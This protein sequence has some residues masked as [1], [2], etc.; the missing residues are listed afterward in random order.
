VSSSS[1]VTAKSLLVRRQNVNTKY[2]APGVNRLGH[3]LFEREPSDVIMARATCL[4]GQLAGNRALGSGVQTVSTGTIRT[5]VE[6]CIY[7]SMRS[8]VMIAN[9]RVYIR[10]NK[11]F[12]KVLYVNRFRT[13][14]R[15]AVYIYIYIIYIRHIHTICSFFVCF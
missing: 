9:K 13:H 5:S 15:N 8:I 11:T 7:S 12:G 4:V 2:C 3:F 10:N 14:R 6:E 1:T